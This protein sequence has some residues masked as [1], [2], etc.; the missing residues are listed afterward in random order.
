[1]LR[2]GK[3]STAHIMNR[4]RVSL[5]GEIAGSA[6]PWE[7]RSYCIVWNNRGQ[8]IQKMATPDI[9]YLAVCLLMMILIYSP[10]VCGSADGEFQ[11]SWSIGAYME[12]C[13]YEPGRA[14][15]DLT[16]YSL[17]HTL[18]CISLVYITC[19]MMDRLATVQCTTWQTDARTD[20]QSTILCQ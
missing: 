11:S 12:L 4:S 8:H 1:M 7:W 5:L 3:C 15:L 18:C 6:D 13:F 17:V 2:A 10:D 9:E 19:C 14:R 16:C 20:R